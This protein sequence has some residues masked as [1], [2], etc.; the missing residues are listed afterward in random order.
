MQAKARKSLGVV[1]E[2]QRAEHGDRFGGDGEEEPG[3]VD[4]GAEAGLVVAEH[5]GDERGVDEH[6]LERQAEP[7]T[8]SRRGSTSRG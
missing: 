8:G 6:D 2:E 1:A 5:D 7:T 3:A 4:A